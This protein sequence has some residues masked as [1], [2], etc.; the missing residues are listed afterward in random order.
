[1]LTRYLRRKYGEEELENMVR[2]SMD[3]I[4]LCCFGVFYE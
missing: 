4:S 2:G 1:M 3:N